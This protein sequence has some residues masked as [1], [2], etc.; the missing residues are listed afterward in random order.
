MRL[1]TPLRG[2]AA[3]RV[4]TPRP[5]LAC[6]AA[7]DCLARR[8]A[9]GR[10]YTYRTPC[11]VFPLEGVARRT[12]DDRT[13]DDIISEARAEQRRQLKR[14]VSFWGAYLKDYLKL[15][16]A[17]T[18]WVATVTSSVLFV[19]SLFGWDPAAVRLIVGTMA[20]IAVM[21]LTYILTDVVCYVPRGGGHLSR[22]QLP[23]EVPS[24][25][26]GVA[27]SIVLR[28]GFRPR[29]WIVATA[30]ALDELRMKSPR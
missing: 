17:V 13:L 25:H 24:F 19:L 8:S 11:P 15:P 26:W 3:A 16:V 5:P 18:F 22:T 12:L 21:V 10:R 14:G 9:D 1:S 23:S 29:V 28:A 2:P 20:I 6:D 30:D 7:P 4:A 27:A